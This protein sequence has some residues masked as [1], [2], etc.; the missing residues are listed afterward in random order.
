MAA[1]FEKPIMA[2]L[3]GAFFHNERKSTQAA[4]T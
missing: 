3:Q 2:A 1:D 4:S